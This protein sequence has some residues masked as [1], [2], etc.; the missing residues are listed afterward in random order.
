MAILL[1]LLDD[2]D[3]VVSLTISLSNLE[4]TKLDNPNTEAHPNVVR[5]NAING[6]KFSN[7]FP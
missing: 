1:L 5:L 3:D 7:T 2:D 6:P 4:S